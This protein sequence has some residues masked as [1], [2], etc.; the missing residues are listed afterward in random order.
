MDNKNQRAAGGHFYIETRSFG[1]H[2]P[3]PAILAP[4]LPVRAEIAG[5]RGPVMKPISARHRGCGWVCG[6]QRHGAAGPARCEGWRAAAPRTARS[7]SCLA[8]SRRAWH[9]VYSM[10]GPRR[11]LEEPG[12]PGCRHGGLAHAPAPTARREGS[13]A[14]RCQGRTAA[15][16]PM[17]A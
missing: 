4:L 12:T 2:G 15:D 13:R 16:H 8:A 1:S 9:S 5:A 10:R 14:R 7:S 11:S 17:T 3:A 6:L